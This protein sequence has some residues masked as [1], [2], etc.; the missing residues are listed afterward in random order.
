MPQNIWGNGGKALLTLK[1]MEVNGKL[2]ASAALSLGQEPPIP[3]EQE[4]G[5]APG[6][7]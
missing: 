5:R 1:E 7:V 4:G 6:T 3:V 2:Y